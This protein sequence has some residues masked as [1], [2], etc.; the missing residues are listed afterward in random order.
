LRKAGLFAYSYLKSPGSATDGWIRSINPQW[1]G[2]LPALF[3]YD[4][5]NR[6]AAK[7]IGETDLQEV[8]A[9]TLSLASTRRSSAR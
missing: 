6:L 8:E 7:F 9:Q 1:S 2:A 4:R 5:Q 3:L